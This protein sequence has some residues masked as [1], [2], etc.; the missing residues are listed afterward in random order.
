LTP[1]PH[2]K[3]KKCGMVLNGLQT[4]WHQQQ[5]KFEMTALTTTFRVV[6]DRLLPAHA[7]AS[8]LFIT[9]VVVVTK[10]AVRIYWFGSKTYPVICVIG[11]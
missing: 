9:I 11:F 6:C 4:F 7:V 3:I 2:Q 5:K 1:P 10:K 8:L